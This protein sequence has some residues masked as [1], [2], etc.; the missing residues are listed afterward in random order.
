MLTNHQIE[1]VSPRMNIP[2]EYCGF[3]D[4]IPRLKVDKTYIINL[5]DATDDKGNPNPGSHWTAFQIRNSTNGPKCFYFDSYGVGEPVAVRRRVTEAFGPIKIYQNTKDVQSLMSDACGYFC[6][7]WAHFINDPRFK[8]SSIKA[9]SDN[10]LSMFNNLEKSRDYMFNEHV[11]RHFF[12]AKDR[13]NE[14]INVYAD[15]DEIIK[16]NG[17]KKV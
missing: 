5:E 16:S 7:A 14:P 13:K 17:S 10:F 3:K 4:R 1:E 8:T 9:D 15:L 2:L 6:L 12:L 11:L